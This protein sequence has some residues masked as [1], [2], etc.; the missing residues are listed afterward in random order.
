MLSNYTLNISI[1]IFLEDSFGNNCTF[2]RQQL[3]LPDHRSISTVG[4]IE[5]PSL[6]CSLITV[7][8]VEENRLHA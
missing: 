7:I 8:R 3:Y 5:G 6:V 4:Y 2:L 1:D